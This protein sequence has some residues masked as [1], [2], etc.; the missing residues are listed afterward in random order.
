MRS[1]WLSSRIRLPLSIDR[2]FFLL[3]LTLHDFVPHKGIQLITPLVVIVLIAR[4]SII[5]LSPLFLLLLVGCLGVWH[6]VLL[7][8]YDLKVRLRIL[9]LVVLICLKSLALIEC[10]AWPTLLIMRVNLSFE[11][12]NVS[13]TKMSE[14]LPSHLLV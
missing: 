14:H 13:S 5:T 4:L 9:I 8:P 11:I 2:A 10:K 3:V 1:F 12:I 7:R 6:K